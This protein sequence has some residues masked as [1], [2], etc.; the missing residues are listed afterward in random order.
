MHP[1]RYEQTIKNLTKELN[2][3][4]YGDLN[5]AM[6]LLLTNPQCFFE[7]MER[8]KGK[9]DYQDALDAYTTLMNKENRKIIGK[10]SLRE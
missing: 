8:F 3:P 9:R 1:M 2:H 4:L 7:E 6:L 10:I 5:R